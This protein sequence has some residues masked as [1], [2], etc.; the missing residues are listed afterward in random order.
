MGIVLQWAS[1][2]ICATYTICWIPLHT[3]RYIQR[4]VEN[5]KFSTHP[6]VPFD[7][8]DRFNWRIPRRNHTNNNKFC[9]TWPI[10]CLFLYYLKE[11]FVNWI[12]ITTSYKE[13][14]LGITAELHPFYYWALI[15]AQSIDVALD[16]FEK[17]MHQEYSMSRLTWVDL[18]LSPS[19]CIHISSKVHPYKQII[20]Q[21]TSWYV[22]S[23]I[24]WKFSSYQNIVQA[25]KQV[26]LEHLASMY[27]LLHAA[28]ITEVDVQMFDR[29]GWAPDLSHSLQH[30]SWMSQY[31]VA[32]SGAAWVMAT[33]GSPQ[34]GNE[35]FVSSFQGIICKMDLPPFTEKIG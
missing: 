29:W 8:S 27:G 16:N 6:M 18:P 14:K 3:G 4:S 30:A 26:A 17:E 20:Q 5:N 13:K 19:L 7:N 33:V 23:H 15:K 31:V 11:G 10:D 32:P 28:C 24:Y 9:P 22:L 35:E 2:Y 25:L 1:L 12:A 21:R 34:D